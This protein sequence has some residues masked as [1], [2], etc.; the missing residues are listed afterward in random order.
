MKSKGF[1]AVFLDRDGVINEVVFRDGRPASPRTLDEFRLCEGVGPALAQL[2]EAGFRLFVVSNQPD[3]A[4]GFLAPSVLHT[5]SERIQSILPVERVLT[6][7]HDDADS[8]ACRKPKPGMLQDVAFSE[9]IDLSRSFIIGD[10]WRDVQA[11][12]HAGCRTILLQRPYNR[13]VQADYLV[14]GLAKAAQLVLGEPKHGDSDSL[15]RHRLSR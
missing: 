10:S 5:I 3:I 7:I 4:R 8:C 11:G 15:V 2:A 13:G 1:C 9:G 6:C 12:A 14:E